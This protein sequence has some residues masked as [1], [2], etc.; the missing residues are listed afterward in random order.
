MVLARATTRHVSCLN[1]I[2]SRVG[3][4]RGQVV[5]SPLHR[6]SR[7]SFHPTRDFTRFAADAVEVSTVGD[8]CTHERPARARGC[9]TRSAEVGIQIRVGRCRIGDSTCN[10]RRTGERRT[11]FL[12]SPDLLCAFASARGVCGLRRSQTFPASR[13]PV[14]R[15][16]QSIDDG[17]RDQVGERSA[18]SPVRGSPSESK[19]DLIRRATAIASLDAPR[20]IA[21]PS[22]EPR[23]DVTRTRSR[24]R[25]FSWQPQDSTRN[26]AA[27]VG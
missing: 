12:F 21:R 25:S 26:Q 20:D 9:E 11:Y 27:A 23:A 22:M 2:D 7:R 16:E 6:V 10:N 17:W 18:C 5:R 3:V 24:W 15:R 1:L 14:F 13:N 8:R 4:G 19:A